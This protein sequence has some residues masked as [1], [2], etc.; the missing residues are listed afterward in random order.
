MNSPA[1]EIPRPDPVGGE[2]RRPLVKRGHISVPLRKHWHHDALLRTLGT[3]G[4][5]ILSGCHH[6]IP[7][8]AVAQL[9]TSVT[10]GQGTVRRIF[11]GP[12]GS[13]LLGAVVSGGANPPVVVWITA[14]GKGLIS[15]YLFDARGRNLTALALVRFAD[16]GKPP[17]APV[18]TPAVPH[19]AALSPAAFRTVADGARSIAQGTG[20]RILWIFL[21]PNCPW[22]HRLYEDLAKALPGDVT[23]RWIPVA[24]LKPSS[25]GRARALL[26]GGLPALRTDEDRFEA[27]DEEGGVPE[28][29]PDP[30]LDAL[31]R[32]NNALLSG[33]GGTKVPMLVWSGPSGPE[34][35]DGYPPTP[36]I[37]A[38]ILG[39]VR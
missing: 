19:P 30:A 37:L 22:C 26:A 31:V 20:K 11:D 10:H 23:V 34:R 6:G 36:E 1:L 27:G 16:F 21:D 2:K 38:G 7:T 35:F 13:G 12:P 39:T 29:A 18:P 15:G 14:D 25:A 24:F 33:I 8:S 28:T 4:A 3:L 17:Q 32:K 5:L 9:V